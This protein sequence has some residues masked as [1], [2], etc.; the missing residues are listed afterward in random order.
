MI[1]ISELIVDL[2]FIRN[3]ISVLRKRLG[4]SKKICAVVKADA[5]GLGAKVICKEINSLV[6]FFAVSCEREFLEIKGL[7]NKPI[8]ILD[9]IYENITKLAKN[10]CQFCVSNFDCLEKILRLAK[11]NRDVKY[12]IHL[13][14]NTGMNRF[15]F[16]DELDLI[17]AFEIVQKTQN[18]F[19]FGVFS[20][21]YCGNIEN[22]AKNQV[23][24]F[25]NVKYCLSKNFDVS[26]VIFHIA[27][28]SGFEFGKNF[29]M[30]RI[31]LGLFLNQNYSCFSLESK[32]IEI[33][34][35]KSGETVGYGYKFLAEK[36]MRVA[37]VSI[38]YADGIFRNIAAKGF[39]LIGGNFCKILSVCMDSIIVDVSSNEAKI[40][41][42]VVLIGKSGDKQIFICDIAAW[43]DTIEYEIMTSLSKRIK[44]L[45]IGGKSNANYNRKVSCKKTRCS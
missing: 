7:V 9:P 44:R 6:D 20:H 2:K 45:Y 21:F 19:I 15:G 8:I 24:R 41:D 25:L 39:V 4:D 18:V 32:I 38:G 23:E 1:C 37:V 12:Q 13:A 27:N 26:N 43:C 10:Y 42:K 35:I 5:Y 34:N 17:K 33:Q 28:T 29:D 40:G 30:C 16:L 22:F 36:S 14:V 31:G 3:N 11:R